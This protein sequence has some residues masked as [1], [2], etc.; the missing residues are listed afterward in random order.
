M[1]MTGAQKLG[2]VDSNKTIF[3]KRNALHYRFVDI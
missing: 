2:K 3:V 1:R